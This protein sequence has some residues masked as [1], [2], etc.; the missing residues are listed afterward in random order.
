VDMDVDVMDI[1]KVAVVLETNVQRYSLANDDKRQ[2]RL[3]KT[4]NKQGYIY[5]PIPKKAARPTA[6]SVRRARKTTTPW[7]SIALRGW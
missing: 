7:R 3:Y 6:P 4:R 5:P 2:N 1:K